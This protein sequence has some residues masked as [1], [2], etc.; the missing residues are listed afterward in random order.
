MG[1]TEGEEGGWTVAVVGA[2]GGVGADLIEAL[3]R[4]S[5]PVG[6]WVLYASRSNTD[7]GVTVDGERHAVRPMPT[8]LADDPAM[9]AVDLVVFATPAG[10][11]AQQGPALAEAGIAVLDLSGDLMGE[12]PL[13][14]P[15][16]D[17]R[18]LAGFVEKRMLASPS[19]AAVL[20]STVLAPLLAGGARA[21]R[22]TVVLSA[23]DAGK[24]GMEELSG[25]VVALFNHSDPPRACFPDGL[26]FDLQPHVGEPGEGWTSRE[27][28]LSMEVGAILGLPPDQVELTVVRAPLFSGVSASLFIEGPEGLTVPKATELLSAVPTLTVE[29]RGAQGPRRLI[30]RAR[31]QVGRLRSLQGGGVALWAA[32]DNLRFGSSGNAVAILSAL[33]RARLL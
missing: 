6:A 13:V 4:S 15:A 32:A 7:G 29:A 2:T 18:P 8:A 33:N 9:D 27:R 12:A 23:S 22:G 24:A 3:G 28:R 20:L 21:V 31:A 30:G 25:Q 16:V 17:M 5:F 10:V 11:A 19:A 14:V 26:A 1:S